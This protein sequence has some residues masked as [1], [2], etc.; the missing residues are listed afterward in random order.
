MPAWS[1]VLCDVRTL[2]ERRG[3]D[4]QS[5]TWPKSPRGCVSLF[6]IPEA[7]SKLDTTPRRMLQEHFLIT[8]VASVH[9][10]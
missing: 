6:T 1:V 8:S 7:S 2:R 9:L 5:R 10:H 4:E 3:G